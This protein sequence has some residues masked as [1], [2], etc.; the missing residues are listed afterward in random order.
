M[1]ELIDTLLDI[2]RLEA[3]QVTPNLKEVELSVIVRDLLAEFTP[4][5]EKRD[6]TLVENIAAVTIKTDPLL[7]QE[8]FANLVSNALKYT[9]S[10]GKIT[11]TLRKHKEECL[12]KVTDTGYGIPM[13]SQSL[14]FTKFFRATNVS[15]SKASGTG[16][17]L[18]M[19]KEIAK[20]LGGKIWFKSEENKGSTFY[21]SLPLK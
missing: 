3:G 16:L 8:V 6:I 14:I 11:V 2:T 1:N 13:E 21:V 7:L 12:F 10:G 18:Y 4:M 19:A 15:S 17:G 5:A 20:I 9:P